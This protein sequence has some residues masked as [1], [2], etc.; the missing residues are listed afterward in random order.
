MSDQDISGGDATL[1]IMTGIGATGA[2][3]AALMQ[4]ILRSRCETIKCCGAECTR[5][6]LPPTAL[7]TTELNRL[8]NAV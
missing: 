2:A 1:L 4:C 8:G 6:V 3:L 5:R 7:D